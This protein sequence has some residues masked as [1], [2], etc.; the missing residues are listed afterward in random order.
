MS[1]CKAGVC[2]L[3]VLLLAASPAADDS[4]REARARALFEDG[5][6]AYE[7]SIYQTAY[8]SLNEP[9]LL[10]NIAS[11]LQGL[12]RPHDAAEAL[13]SFLRLQPQD[14]DRPE[15]EK[16]IGNLEEEQRLLDSEHR[17]TTP[18]V[19]PVVNP[20]VTAPVLTTTVPPPPDKSASR[21][22]VVIAVVCSIAAV[23]VAGTAIG[24]GIG[25][26]SSS[27]EPYTPAQ[28]GPVPGTK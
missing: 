16:R 18:P 26:S 8:D 20:I 19:V 24:L 7:T 25:L 28:I 11:A 1:L 2:I 3:T 17:P 6:K 9:A 10:Y 27:T 13:R 23:I 5:R 22:K 14:P 12:K 15:I 21:R 4:A